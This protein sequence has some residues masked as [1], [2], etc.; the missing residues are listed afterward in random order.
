MLSTEPLAMSA[1]SL[2]Q[3]MDTLQFRTSGAPR[4]SQGR[5]LRKREEKHS[6]SGAR[7]WKPQAGAADKLAARLSS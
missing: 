4:A 5:F 7:P 1:K 3:R 2:N 6:L